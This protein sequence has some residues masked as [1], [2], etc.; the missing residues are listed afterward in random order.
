VN[1]SNCSSRKS[2]KPTNFLFSASNC[3]TLSSRVSVYPL[4]NA[5]RRSLSDTIHSSPTARQVRHGFWPSHLVFFARHRS[6][7]WATLSTF[8]PGAFIVFALWSFEPVIVSSLSDMVKACKLT[9]ET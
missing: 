7:A 5:L 3:R 2:T 8:D 6:H 9:E 1:R 4:G